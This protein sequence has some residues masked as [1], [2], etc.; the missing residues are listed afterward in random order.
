MIYRGFYH[1][2]EPFP[3]MVKD[4]TE[5]K[6]P[7]QLKE[8]ELLNLRIFLDKSVLEVFANDR[9]CLTQRIYPSK[10]ESNEIRLFAKGGAAK[11]KVVKAWDMDQAIPW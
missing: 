4:H 2:N 11:A 6:A 7:F 8:G 10:E 3:E 1:T 9:Q 5:Q